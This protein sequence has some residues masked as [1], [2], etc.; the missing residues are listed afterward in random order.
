MCEKR[1]DFDGPHAR[2]VP[3]AAEKNEAFN[4]IQIGLFGAQTVVLHANR[5]ADLIEQAKRGN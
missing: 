3:L 4:P 2:R 1:L 5:V